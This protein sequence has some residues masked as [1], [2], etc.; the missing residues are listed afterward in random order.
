M[1]AALDGSLDRRRL[2]DPAPVVDVERPRVVEADAVRG[3]AMRDP[4]PPVRTHPGAA[5]VPGDRRVAADASRCHAA[6]LGVE[7]PDVVE[8]VGAGLA[9][10]DHE[11]L[12]WQPGRLVTEARRGRPIDTFPL[13]ALGHEVERPQVVEDRGAVA[14]TEEVRGPA[15]LGDRPGVV[16]ARRGTVAVHLE[17]RPR[18][19]RRGHGARAAAGSG[20]RL[21]RRRVASGADVA[22]AVGSGSPKVG[23]CD[24][25]GWQ[26]A[27]RDAAT[28]ATTARRAATVR[29]ARRAPR[30]ARSAGR[31]RGSRWARR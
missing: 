28:R 10:P 11:A 16:L 26:A 1:Q 15:V 27:R 24:A 14:S 19:G 18:G 30:A 7:Q 25:A 12:P 9:C 5:A 20:T 22:G 8:E 17:P 31:S 4:E 2:V 3:E 29:P 6:R 21:G 23:S 13:P